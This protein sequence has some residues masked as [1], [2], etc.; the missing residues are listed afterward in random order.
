MHL[1]KIL[2][3][4]FLI[5]SIT[6]TCQNSIIL[7]SNSEFKNSPEL[8]NALDA[9]RTDNNE[10]LFEDV[11]IFTNLINNKIGDEVINNLQI[12]LNEAS[13]ISFTEEQLIYAN[14]KSI[15]D[16]DYILFVESDAK[17]IPHCKSSLYLYNTNDLV[18]YSK[19][20]NDINLEFDFT[21]Y[22]KSQANINFESVTKDELSLELYRILQYSN[23]AISAENGSI[24]YKTQNIYVNQKDTLILSVKSSIYDDRFLTWEVYGKNG[25]KENHVGSEVKINGLKWTSVR[26]KYKRIK[27]SQTFNIKWKYGIKLDLPYDTLNWVGVN[28]LFE[29]KFN[30]GKENTNRILDN[31][32]SNYSSRY[33]NVRKNLKWKREE[34]NIEKKSK[35]RIRRFKLTLMDKED[36]VFGQ[37]T[38]T[39]KN[40]IKFPLEIQFLPVTKSSINNMNLYQDDKFGIKPN[41]R[42]NLFIWK[43]LYIGMS[44]IKNNVLTESLISNQ[45]LLSNSI[46]VF[47]SNRSY[48]FGFSDSFSDYERKFHLSDF[49]Y[50]VFLRVQ[51]NYIRAEKINEGFSTEFSKYFVWGGVSISKSFN[52]TYLHLIRGFINVEYPF[53]TYNT[54]M[55]RSL[56][57][58]HSNYDDTPVRFPMIFSFGI[59]FSI[60]TLY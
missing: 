18:K 39:F 24:D 29:K 20:N 54:S 50:R 14:A 17:C 7:L 23:L 3:F 43:G 15:L 37:D 44:F 21:T 19:Q 56:K 25:L 55:I 47:S 8:Y 42:L 34:I 12:G 48:I 28:C 11:V 22:P 46:S 32:S 59:T 26:L 60:P 40:Y 53:S 16:S 4:L 31:I 33:P 13:V 41:L 35:N 27:E 58:F 45:P 36:F 9:L 38:I 2:A 57:S 10:Y 49:R 51:Q 5:L 52:S 1:N 30:L 6:C